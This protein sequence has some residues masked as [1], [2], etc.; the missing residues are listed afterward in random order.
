MTEK[1][2]ARVVQEIE[3]DVDGNGDKVNDFIYST[4]ADTVSALQG[5][6]TRMWARSNS[7]KSCAVDS[8]WK[9]E[10]RRAQRGTLDGAIKKEREVTACSQACTGIGAG[11]VFWED[12]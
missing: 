8:Q 10:R 5:P 3:L 1:K 12:E 2:P 6:A 4:Q 11:S 9:Q 7:G